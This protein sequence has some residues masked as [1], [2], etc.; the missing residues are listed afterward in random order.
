MKITS[1]IPALL[2]GAMLAGCAS[3]SAN[4]YSKDQMRQLATVQ[5]GVVDNVRSV[6]MQNPSGV[7]AAAGGVIGGVAAG[8][9]IGGGNGQIVSGIL[10]AIIGGIIG[11]TIEKNVNSSDALELTVR[12]SN[13]QRVV[14]V[15]EA[16]V[17][18]QLG[19]CVDVISNGR[20]SRV[21]P[22][23]RC[24]GDTPPAKKTSNTVTTF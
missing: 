21:A 24:D 9:N 12:L 14:V 10:G 19:Q 6:K 1:L 13:G 18:F 4:V 23:A 3:D 17:Q 15:Q 11:N 22:A 7:G 8:G 20:S 2:L 16:D 5:S